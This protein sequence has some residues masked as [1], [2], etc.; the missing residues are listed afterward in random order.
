MPAWR[1]PDEEP[2]SAS[3]QVAKHEDDDSES[4]TDIAEGSADEAAA[5]EAGPEAASGPTPRPER[6]L[7]FDEDAVDID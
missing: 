4:D 6:A 3:G 7:S 5:P 1:R 2:G